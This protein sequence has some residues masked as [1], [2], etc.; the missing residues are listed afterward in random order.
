MDF[1]GA[2]EPLTRLKSMGLMLGFE[3]DNCA[4]TA[5]VVDDKGLRI[6]PSVVEQPLSG[7]DLLVVPDGIGTRTLQHDKAFVDWL[8]SSE[9]VKLKV[10]V[11]TGSLL[12]ARL[13]QL[14]G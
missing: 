5:D 12:L 11:C 14:T 8:R 7:Y 4:L 1:I 3:W 6:A 10:S 9:P 13:S 2:Y